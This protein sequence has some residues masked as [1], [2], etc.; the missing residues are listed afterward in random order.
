M[1]DI[2]QILIDKSVDSVLGT[3]TQGGGIEDPFITILM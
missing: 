2:N 1:H 3:R